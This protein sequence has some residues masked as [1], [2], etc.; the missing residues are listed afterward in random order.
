MEERFLDISGKRGGD[1]DAN[2][3]E[4]LLK[5]SSNLFFKCIEIKI[6]L[7]AMHVVISLE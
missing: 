7:S 6:I 2:K 5:I 1:L 4:Y 3:W